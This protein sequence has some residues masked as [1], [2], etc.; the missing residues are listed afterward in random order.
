MQLGEGFIVL[1]TGK[2][3]PLSRCKARQWDEMAVSKVESAH[4]QQSGSA[5]RST[6]VAR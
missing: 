2:S 1:E 6:Y 3:A 5:C 4:A